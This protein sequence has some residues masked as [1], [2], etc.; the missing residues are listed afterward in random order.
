MSHPRNFKLQ[1]GFTLIEVILVIV[2]LSIGLTGLLVYVSQAAQDSAYAHNISTATTLAQDLM[3]EIRSKCWDETATAT[4]VCSGA[5]TA[6]AIGADGGEG[7]AAYDDVDDFNSLPVAGN[8]PPQDSQ[9]LAMAAFPYF[10]QS[11]SVC[12]VASTALDT[13]IAGPTDYKRAS[14]TISW[15]AADQ[16]NVVNVFSNHEM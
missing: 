9:G 16:V 3:E 8:T 5:V 2:V 13:C 15:S 6:S 10:T 11:A 14:V 12:Y 4:A 7:R 1:G